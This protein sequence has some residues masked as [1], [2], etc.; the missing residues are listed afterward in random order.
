MYWFLYDHGLR[1][2]RIKLTNLG[3][4]HYFPLFSCLMNCLYGSCTIVFAGFAKHTL[5]EVSLT[6]E[7]T[8]RYQTQSAIEFCWP[9]CVLGNFWRLSLRC[10]LIVCC[11][12]EVVKSLPFLLCQFL[13]KQPFRWQQEKIIPKFLKDELFGSSSVDYRLLLDFLFL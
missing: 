5:K 8:S 4:S 9:H 1:H 6:K 2:E 12:R 3:S 13:H 10:L 11:L 7:E